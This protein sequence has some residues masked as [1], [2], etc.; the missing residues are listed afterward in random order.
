VVLAAVLAVVGVVALVVGLI[1]EPAGPHRVA[2]GPTAVPAAQ[3]AGASVLGRSE[4]VRLRI[5]AIAVDTPLLDLGLRDDGRVE[6]PPLDSPEAGWYRYSPTPGERGPAVLLGHVDSAKS[7]PGVFYDL[8]ALAPGDP[9]E[10]TRADGSTVSF[11]VDRIG[12]Y[13]KATFPSADVY[14]DVPGAEL[15]LI[16]C[17]GAFDEGSGHYEDNI[18]VYAVAGATT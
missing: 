18:V 2:A 10:V 13:P 4:P 6:V 12:H 9:I 8:P 15:R 16:T 17:G 3:A 7:G 1:G 11:V 14:G 5:P